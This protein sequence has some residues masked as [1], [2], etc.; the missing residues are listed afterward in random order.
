MAL[1]PVNVSDP[2]LRTIL[3]K[4]NKALTTVAFE[5]IP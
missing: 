4:G 2:P 3:L 5:E 1:L